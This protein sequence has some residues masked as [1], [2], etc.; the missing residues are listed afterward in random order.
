MASSAGSELGSN[1][2][3]WIHDQSG[4]RPV[5]S[6]GYATNPQL[7]ADGRRLFFLVRTSAEL[8]LYE[9]RAMA[10]KSQI[11]GPPAFVPAPA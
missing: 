7:S 5:V 2:L 4:E 11:L 3:D 1:P 10:R 6:E 8:D 9:L